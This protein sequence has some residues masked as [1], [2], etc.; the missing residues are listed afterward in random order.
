[1][2]DRI[3]KMQELSLGIDSSRCYV[4][5]HLGLE[6]AIVVLVVERPRLATIVPVAGLLLAT[7]SL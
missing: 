5:A 1:M 6:V 4:I 2:G 7:I 3:G